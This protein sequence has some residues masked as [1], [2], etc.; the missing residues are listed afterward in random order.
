MTKLFFV[1]AYNAIKNIQNY[2]TVA[3]RVIKDPTPQELVPATIGEAR[4]AYALEKKNLA[5]VNNP[6]S[7]I[8]LLYA[9]IAAQEDE[10][11]SPF[12]GKNK[13][14]E[15][16][17]GL[18]E[19]KEEKQAMEA[20]LKELWKQEVESPFYTVHETADMSATPTGIAL[21]NALRPYVVIPSEVSEEEYL[22]KWEA[23]TGT[24]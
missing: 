5:A 17:N 11:R 16:V 8:S 15:W 9:E 18:C 19:T 24:K 23:E 10:I 7:H 21:C 22:A 13:D 3:S 12:M 6:S 20:E 4:L 1:Q 14:G 2:S